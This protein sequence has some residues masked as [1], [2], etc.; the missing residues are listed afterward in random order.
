[1]GLVIAGSNFAHSWANY[2]SEFALV[3]PDNPELMTAY[4]SSLIKK[5]AERAG[6][7]LAGD[8]IPGLWSG[9]QDRVVGAQDLFVLRKN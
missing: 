2:G 8:P 6:L 5:M 1:M 4:S 3:A 7:A 9:T